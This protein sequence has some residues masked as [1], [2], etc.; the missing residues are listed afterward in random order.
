VPVTFDHSFHPVEIIRFT[1]ET[2]DEEYR[3]YLADTDRIIAR[4]VRIAIVVDA[5]AAE[6]TPKTQRRMQATWMKSNAVLHRERVA[7]MAFLI[8][9]PAIRGVLTAI[10]WLQPLPMPHRVL[11]KLEEGI[12]WCREQLG[13]ANQASP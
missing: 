1:G 3:A 12:E 10:L 9:S 7:C 8:D 4:A 13:I 5:R 11:K 2:T 6:S